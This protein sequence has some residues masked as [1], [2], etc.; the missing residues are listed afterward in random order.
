MY[1]ATPNEKITR[2]VNVMNEAS[3]RIDCENLSGRAF[4]FRSF[5]INTIILVQNAMPF[6]SF[7]TSNVNLR[8][9]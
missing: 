2:E 3:V 6:H 7:R 4:E 8:R 1:R 5:D 9:L